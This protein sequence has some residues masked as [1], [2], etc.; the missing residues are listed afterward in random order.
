MRR[1]VHDRIE[2]R[3]CREAEEELMIAESGQ[4]G[5]TA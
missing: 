2:S 1:A 3:F 5:P 4:I